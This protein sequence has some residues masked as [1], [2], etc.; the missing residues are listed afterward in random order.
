MA[1]AMAA[2]PQLLLAD[3]PTG[4]LD[5]ATGRALI[6]SLLGWLAGSRIALVIA[7]HDPTIAERMDQVW[8]MEHGRLSPPVGGN[9]R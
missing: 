8:R 9:A 4:Q 7:T 6:D 5:Q 3:E 2:H 1:R